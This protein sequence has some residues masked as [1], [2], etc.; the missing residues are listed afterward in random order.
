MAASAPTAVKERQQIEEK[1]R[2][3]LERLFADEAAFEAEF[4]AVD[5]MA[6]TLESYKGT[7]ASAARL[8]EFYKIEDHLDRILSKLHVYA[9]QRSD[10]DTGNQPAQARNTRVRGKVTEVRGKLA[11]LRPELLALPAEELAS[12]IQA[13]E[14]RDYRRSI[15]LLLRDKPHTLTTAEET[16]LSR[17]GEIFSA[18]YTTFNLFSNADIKFPKAKGAD[19]TE[20]DVTQGRLALLLQSADRE[21]RKSAFGCV[22]DTYGQFRNTAASLLSSNVKTGNYL[23]ASRRFG[24]ALEAALHPNAVPVSLTDA[25]VAAI[26]GALPHFHHYVDVRKKHLG[27]SDPNM[28]DFHVSIVPDFELEVSFEQAAEWVTAAMEPMGPEY[29]SAVRACFN[30]RWTD[31]FENKGKRSGAYSSG[32]YD[33]VPYMLLNFQGTLDDVF[34]LAHELGHSIHTWMANKHQSSRYAE[35]SIF[36]A[37]I[38]STTA[39]RLLLDYLL[40][41]QND[42]KLRAYLLN[43][44]ANSFRTTVYRQ[45]MFHEYERAVHEADQQGT[46]L[47]ADWLSET[48]S[49]LNAAYY[50]P[51]VQA[52]PRIALEWARIPHFYYNFYVYQYAT[53]FISAQLFAK[54]I[55]SGEAGREQYLSMLRAGGSMDPIDAV[56]LGG[57]DLTDPT[58]LSGAFKLFREA[59][60]ELDGALDALK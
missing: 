54:Q 49:K 17:A 47:T 4:A 44:Y 1:Y 51:A 59:V 24:S 18:S 52:D 39:E 15:E 20:H 2:W 57:V 13:P 7:I 43:D 28:W 45:T 38:A 23:A 25:L 31:V 42:P 40:R 36:V 56:K 32:C 11:W 29:M 60:D 34:T 50:G 9:H 55:Q 12:W 30:E 19:G 5:G 35:Y 21:L 48:Y 22:Y 58:V 41:T 10:E 37:E 46:A 6:A 8:A 26:H 16:L 14:L 27:I 53:G 33:S 3:D